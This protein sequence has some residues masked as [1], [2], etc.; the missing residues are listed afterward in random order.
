MELFSLF[1]FFAPLHE[2]KKK[3]RKSSQQFCSMPAKPNRKSFWS[4]SRI[5][6]SRIFDPNYLLFSRFCNGRIFA[7]LWR[8]RQAK[9]QRKKKNTWFEKL[10]VPKTSM[11]A[12]FVASIPSE[13]LNDVSVCVLCAFAWYAG[14]NR[15]SLDVL[16]RRRTLFPITLRIFIKIDPIF[17]HERP[18]FISIAAKLAAIRI[19]LNAK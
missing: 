3:K 19:D 16:D 13:K 15:K 6:I 10:F 17:H 14:V 11:R 4:K 8:K 1:S 9:I 18:K 12:I 7:Q 2:N 5:N